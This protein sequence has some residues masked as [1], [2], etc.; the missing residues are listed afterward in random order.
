[1]RKNIKFD[2]AN[3]ILEIDETFLPKEKNF[4]WFARR[5]TRKFLFG[6]YSRTN[7]FPLMFLI[8]IAEKRQS[9][10]LF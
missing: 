4:A 8:E 2:E 5:R 9:F 3:D 1:M 6:I 10:Q 7:K